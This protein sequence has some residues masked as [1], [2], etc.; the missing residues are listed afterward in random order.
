MNRIRTDP[1]YFLSGAL[2]AAIFPCFKVAHL[3]FSINWQRLVPLYWVGLTERAVL[4]AVILAVIGLPARSTVRPLWSHFMAQKARLFFFAVFIAWALWKF[5]T[6]AGLILIAIA[7]VSTELIDRTQGDIK[8]IGR[9]IRSVIPPALY[10]FLGLILVFAYN[11]VIAAVKDPGGYDWLFLRIDSY[12]LHGHT[13]S[14]LAH[15]ASLKLPSGLL[16]F[17]ETVYYGMFDQIGA[18]ILV[19]SLCQGTKQALRF[20]GTLLT[21]YYLGLLLFY[22]WPSMGPFYTCPDHF[23]HFPQWLSTYASQQGEIWKAK[24]L[25]SPYRGLSKVDT[26]YFIAF[27]CLHLAQPLIVLWF[28]RRWKRIVLCLVAYDLIL[29][30]AILLLEWHYVIDLLGGVVVAVIAILLN[31]GSY[32]VPSAREA[33]VPEARLDTK[34]QES[35]ETV[36]CNSPLS[37]P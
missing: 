20:V 4:A 36:M 11:D 31:P 17:S 18:A 23:T 10:F 8:T 21:A 24:L 32:A 28:M 29:V 12:I 1:H 9:F 34:Q 13:I 33:S 15:T 16:S 6:H 14:S 26:D 19:I 3:P 2:G 5:G 37:S 35:F 27:P 22:L 30:P 25:S 7:I